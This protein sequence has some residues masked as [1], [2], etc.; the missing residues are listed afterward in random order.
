MW[1][2]KIHWTGRRRSEKRHQV[3]KGLQDVRTLSRISGLHHSSDRRT[4][5]Q[6]CISQDRWLI[7]REVP[8]F[9]DVYF[10]LHLQQV[11]SRLLT[12]VESR[13]SD[14]EGT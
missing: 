3:V 9:V 1:S 7:E 10:L 12:R 4:H 11:S 8:V 13:V 5:A 2:H 6:G 14:R